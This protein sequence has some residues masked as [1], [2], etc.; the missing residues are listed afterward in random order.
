MIRLNPFVPMFALHSISYNN[1]NGN[2]LLAEAYKLSVRCS[3]IK[4]SVMN[5]YCFCCNWC[6]IHKKLIVSQTVHKIFFLAF[7]SMTQ[8]Y[9]W[10]IVCDAAK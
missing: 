4:N 2:T 7:L 8:K 3:N 9:L 10:M 1:W 5:F 6:K